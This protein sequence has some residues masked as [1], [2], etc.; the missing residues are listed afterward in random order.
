VKRILLVLSVGAVMAAI[1]VAMSVPAFAAATLT[2]K[3]D[4]PESTNSGNLNAEL[5][6]SFT[7]NGGYVKPDAHGEV[8]LGS[9]DANILD[10][11]QRSG[12]PAGQK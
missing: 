11:L 1:V 12:R 5:S 10:Q 9:R 8:Y 4:P 3:T 2:P 7:Q 6:S